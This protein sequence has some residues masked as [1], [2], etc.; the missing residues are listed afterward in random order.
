MVEIYHQ[1]SFFS[2]LPN[3]GCQGARKVK[4]EDKKDMMNG[5]FSKSISSPNPL[6]PFHVFPVHPALLFSS[7]STPTENK[8]WTPDSHRVGASKAKP[9]NNKEM[10][11]K[12]FSKTLSSPFLFLL[13]SCLV[14]I[15]RLLKTEI[16]H[17][18]PIA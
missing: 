6:F 14:S 5:N 18:T 8:T 16:G 10:M 7:M 1:I 4:Q 12:N 15:P 9:E 13:L 11:N 17:L 2:A 3:Y